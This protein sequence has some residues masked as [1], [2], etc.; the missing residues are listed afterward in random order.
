MFF[1]V[2]RVLL[3]PNVSWAD[4]SN[5][6]GW[7]YFFA[8][9]ISFYPQIISNYKRQSVIGLSLDFVTLN[10]TGF[11]CYL[12]HFVV[13]RSQGQ[14]VH[15]NDL[16]F[17]GHALFC[18]VVMG[19]QCLMYDRGSQQVSRATKFLHALI[20]FA[21]AVNGILLL[22]HAESQD[23]FGEQLG[24]FK[25]AISLFKYAP[26]MYM[27][28]KR[29]ST[30]G[31]SIGNVLLDFTGG[32]FSILQIAAD[33]IHGDY[34]AGLL[35]KLLL[36]LE[37]QTFCVVFMLQHYVWY[38]QTKRRR[39]GAKTPAHTEVRT[40]TVHHEDPDDEDDEEA[41]ET[42]RLLAGAKAGSRY[43]HTAS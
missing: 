17:A 18:S 31:W 25:T 26:Q 38:A 29:Q 37:A 30:V 10:V 42:G 39:G 7:I 14:L 12:L 9:S 19:L 13:R 21:V 28:Y 43:R 23:L 1:P 20:W 15:N 6:C 3:G 32:L 11:S 40:H 35:P 41:G 36:G 2:W 22:R 33:S 34:D 8:W 4:V 16:A 24:L 5:F 27:N